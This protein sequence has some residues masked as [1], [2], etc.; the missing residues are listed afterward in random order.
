MTHWREVLPLDRL[1]EVDYDALV[2]DPETQIRRLIP[3]RGLEWNSACLTPHRNMRKIKTASVWQ[4]R[5][6]I[7]GTSV[8]RWRRYEPWLG[9]LR[10]LAQE[11]DEA[12]LP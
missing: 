8:D 4:A 3:A 6:P 1:I 11:P 12:P 5:Q 7:Y 9:E 2:A 10:D